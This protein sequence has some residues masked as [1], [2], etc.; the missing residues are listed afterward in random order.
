[1]EECITFERDDEVDMARSG[2]QIRID[3]DLNSGRGEESKVKDI[4]WSGTCGYGGTG[5]GVRQQEAV[6]RYRKWLSGMRIA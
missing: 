4:R 2:P 5:C 6:Q 3:I 1:M